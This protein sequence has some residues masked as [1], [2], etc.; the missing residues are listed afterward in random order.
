MRRRTSPRATLDKLWHMASMCQFPEKPS[1]GL[2]ISFDHID[3]LGNPTA[4]IGFLCWAAPKM[5]SERLQAE[6]AELIG[7]C[8]QPITSMPRKRSALSSCRRHLSD[9][10]LDEGSRCDVPAEAGSAR[11]EPVRRDPGYWHPG[12]ARS[13]QPLACLLFDVMM[14]YLARK[15][16]VYTY[17][18]AGGGRRD[19]TAI[20]GSADM[21]SE[22]PR[23][24]A[25]LCAIIPQ[26]P[27]R[28]CPRLRGAFRTRSVPI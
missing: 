28:F 11:S 23:I 4:T 1:P 9:R 3:V 17:T 14:Q 26:A 22:R 18:A 25:T 21:P 6:V 10:T 16:F 24:S 12:S 15:K 13:P 8:W 5:M 19:P 20:R 27:S 2:K 7:D